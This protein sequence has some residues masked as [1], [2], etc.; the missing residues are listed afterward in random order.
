MA[1]NYVAELLDVVDL[2]RRL[3]HAHGAFHETM[4]KQERHG[5]LLKCYC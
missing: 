3:G 1:A 2:G 5:Y 4:Q